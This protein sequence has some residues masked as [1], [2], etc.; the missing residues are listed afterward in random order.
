[1]KSISFVLS[2]STKAFAASS[3]FVPRT[4]AASSLVCTCSC[5]RTVYSCPSSRT[6]I[7]LCTARSSMAASTP[8]APYNFACT[9]ERA[10]GHDAY[11]PGLYAETLSSHF[12]IL[13]FMCFAQP[14]FCRFILHARCSRMCHLCSRGH[15]LFSNRDLRT[16][17]VLLSEL[18]CVLG[19][20]CLSQQ[21]VPDCH[22]LSGYLLAGHTDAPRHE[23]RESV[24]YHR[25]R[26]IL[27]AVRSLAGHRDKW[28]SRRR[29]RC[30]A[31]QDL[32]PGRI[33]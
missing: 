32:H 5:S 15:T 7:R 25:L 6:T 17:C 19:G 22:K 30:A 23:T 26:E 11:S 28:L 33:V 13:L 12:I 9:P 24:L 3:S 21:L 27:S 4:F 1:M 29:G 14:G 8:N 10:V 20:Q 16:C 2:L 18:R 31:L